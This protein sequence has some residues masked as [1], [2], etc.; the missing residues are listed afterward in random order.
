MGVPE[1]H[2]DQDVFSHA[3]FEVSDVGHVDTIAWNKT[4]PFLPSDSRLGLL[5]EEIFRLLYSPSALKIIDS[6]LLNRIRRLD[7]A[8]ESWRLSISPAFRPK[9]S[10]L[11]TQSLP[12][13]CT[14]PNYLRSVQLQLEYHYLLTVIHTPVRRFGATQS[15]ETSLS[16]ELHSVMHSSIDLSLEA[17]RSTLFLLNEPIAM[18]RQETFW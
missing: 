12:S 18:L 15:P 2:L 16:E 9:L 4:L 10:I 1:E 17:S 3:T 8:L 5:K 11:S 7:D 14:F 13:A 6:E